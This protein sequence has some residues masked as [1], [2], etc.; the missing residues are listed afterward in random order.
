V[1]ASTEIVEFRLDVPDADLNDLRERLARTRWP[2]R[3]TVA[4]W[5]Q[6]IPL[7]YVQELCEY[8][9]GGYDWR[10]LEAR[11]NAIGQ[12]RTEIDGLGI[13]FL[14]ARSPHPGA[15]PLLLTHGWP[16]S[17]VEFLKVIGPLVDPPAHGGDAADA[18]DVVCPSLPGYGFSDKP[19]ETGWGVQRIAAAWAQLM[20]RL[21]DERYGA[22]GGDWGAAITTQLATIDSEHLAGIH[23]NMLI[24]SPAELEALGELTDREQAALADYAHHRRWNTGYAR[25][26]STRPQ[27]LGY[28]LVDS[29]AAQCAWIVEKF[30]A[31]TDCEGH[32]ENALTRDELLD[33]VML[34]W[35]PATGASSARLY[36]ESYRKWDFSPISVPTGC[37]IFPKEILRPSRRWAERR[38]SDLRHWNEL[39][40]GGHFAAFEQPELFAD[41]LRAFFRHV[42]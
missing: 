22:Q 25:Q 23:L 7:A 3:E 12:F 38:F 39:D 16:G 41:E 14:H 15:L 35:L 29:P 9:R 30:W 1:A 6:G 8:W 17:V 11:L 20:A 13:H 42:R 18:F 5:S 10:R 24:A 32:P 28:G 27:T 21:G 31:W 2:E 37:S 36:W 40:R 34:Y 26:Q 4:D 33:N 19:G